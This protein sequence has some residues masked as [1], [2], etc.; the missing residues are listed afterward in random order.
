MIKADV[1]WAL[2]PSAIHPGAAGE[3]GRFPFL[4]PPEG[5]NLGF[6]PWALILLLLFSLQLLQS[7]NE[8]DHLALWGIAKG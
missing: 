1:A 3:A 8:R 4:R 6:A 2:M 5:A 7:Y